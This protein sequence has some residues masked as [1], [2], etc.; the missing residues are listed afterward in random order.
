VDE[1]VSGRSNGDGTPATELISIM[2]ASEAC[3][4]RGQP[5]L[6]LAGPIS[7][8]PPKKGRG[9]KKAH[10]IHITA[11]DRSRVRRKRGRT[12]RTPMGG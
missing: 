8:P 9:K 12:A 2:V 10:G 5:K 4:A 7:P 11:C 3:L 6:T 1:W